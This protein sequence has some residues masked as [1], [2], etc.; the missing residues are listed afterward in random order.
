MGKDNVP[1]HTVIFPA[2]I[3]GTGDQWTKLNTLSVSEY[4]NYENGKFSKSRGVGVFGDTAKETGVPP[5]VWRYYLLSN[6]PETSDTQFE[7]KGFVAA[8]NSELLANLGNFVNRVI[9]FVNAKFEGV[10]P[11]FSASYSDDS[12]DFAAW[13]AEIQTILG[14]YNKQMEGVHLR[15][16][17]RR[18]MELSSQG[19]LL[20][21]YRLDNAN[22]AAHPERTHAVIGLALN[23]CHLLAST[24]SPFMPAT[25]DSIARQLNTKL[26]FIP[27]TWDPET[28]K[29]A[30]K[31]GKAEYLFTRIDEKKTDEWKERFGGTQASRA[32]EEAAKKKKQEDKERKKAKKAAAKAG[33]S[34]ATDDAPTTAATEEIKEL[35]V[36]EKEKPVE[37]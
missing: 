30:H 36:R 29:P 12:F 11:E 23:L 28:L 4:L 9:K 25:A 21:Q 34:K 31:I 32:A 2:S 33:A 18:V 1:F 24:V 5:S 8:N 27:D 15:A 37:K 26:A 22:L 10:I 3:M 16:G 7:W 20:L 17:L 13:I 14:D 35:P 19:N 6:R